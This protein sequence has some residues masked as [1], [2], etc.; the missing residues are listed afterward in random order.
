MIK[1]NEELRNLIGSHPLGLSSV[2]KNGNPHCIAVSCV[3]V[4]SENQ[5]LITDVHMLTTVENIKNNPRVCL[6]VWNKEWKDDCFGYV[7]KGKAEHFTDGKWCDE[8][9]KI[10]ENKDLKFKGA[11]LATLDESKRIT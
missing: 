7:L 10:A 8:V 9:A 5:I 2:D 3:K 11:I 1:I 6:V 4:I